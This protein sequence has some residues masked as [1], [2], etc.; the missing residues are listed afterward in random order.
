MIGF[1]SKLFGGNKSDKD[2]KRVL[3]IVN[4]VNRIYTELQTL[5]NDELRNKTQEFRQRIREHLVDIDNQ[6][7][8]KKAEADNNPDAELHEREAIYNEADKLV[9]R[10][11]ELIE[12]VLESIM[13]EAFAVIKEA[14]RRF[15]E[16]EELVSTA[17]DLDKDL[18]IDREHVRIDGD[19]AI[20]KN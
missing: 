9:K 20:Y 13:P 10:R 4:D 2:V 16:N 5:S 3:P 11:D 14:A 17:T 8:E 6:I 1:F 18:A 19:K 15:K 7:A 12:E